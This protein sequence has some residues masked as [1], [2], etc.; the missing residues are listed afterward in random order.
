MFFLILL[1]AVCW[2]ASMS[3]LR[4]LVGRHIKGLRTE[5]R[6]RVQ[7]AK[8][9]EEEKARERK[10]IATGEE[11]PPPPNDFELARE[12]RRLQKRKDDRF[13]N[14]YHLF[15]LGAIVV[16]TFI[17]GYKLMVLAIG[18]VRTAMLVLG[19]ALLGTA[20][21]TYRHYRRN[22]KRFS[23]GKNK[24]QVMAHVIAI[25]ALAIAGVLILVYGL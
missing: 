13:M 10:A 12:A 24:G 6:L 23:E 18:D 3:I 11:L 15:L 2:Y 1:A 21:G 14:I 19:L 7:D 17:I 5:K 8:K 16:I 20:Y 25:P 22:W 4:E 9:A